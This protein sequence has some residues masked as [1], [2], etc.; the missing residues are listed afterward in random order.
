MADMS[1]I[2]TVWVFNGSK[3]RFA[4]AIFSSKQLAIDWITKNRLS[5]VLTRYPLDVSAY[6]WAVA[7]GHFTPSKRSTAHRTLWRS[8]RVQARNIITT[9]MAF[10]VAKSPVEWRR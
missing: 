1:D 9:S 4:S 10:R 7:R 6:E 8:S 2:P 3:A 5:G